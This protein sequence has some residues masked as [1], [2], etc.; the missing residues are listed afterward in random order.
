VIDYTP[1]PD[2]FGPDSFTYT[3]NDGTLGND[4]TATVDI[5]VTGI[6]DPPAATDQSL[7]TPEDAPLLVTL[8][9]TDIDSQCPLTF[10]IVDP[11]ATGTLSPITNEQCTTGS[12]TAEV[13]YT[14]N[15][16]ATGID[17]FTF[18]AND[19]TDT[20][21]TA[22]ITIDVTPIQTMF[23]F[24]PTDDSYVASN[25]ADKNYGSSA[26]VR[27]DGSPEL[28][29]YLLFDVQGVIGTPSVATLRLWA[30][31][32]APSG[33]EVHEVGDTTW[34]ESTIT[35]NTA[36]TFDPIVVGA[37]GP[38]TAGTWTEVDVTG[39]VLG[40][41]LVGFA[42]TDPVSRALSLSSKEGANA[43]EL[44]IDTS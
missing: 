34:D 31:S 32:P 30:N 2:Y 14:P 9:A 21:N 22:T 28:N 38:I 37:S 4:D 15:P 24:S 3:I 23:V 40:D 44:V 35:Y 8:T 11:P 13:T 42:I 29:G 27:I 25:A 12:A 17:T 6:Q 19:G 7:T 43:P 26:K 1:D 18:T 36:P 16:A 33:Y 39:F 20:S 5:T 41:G 10:S